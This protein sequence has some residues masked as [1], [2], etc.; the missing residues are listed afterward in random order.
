AE[1]RHCEILVCL[2]YTAKL[3]AKQEGLEDG[4]R[5]VINDGPKGCLSICVSHSCPPPWRAPNELASRLNKEVIVDIAISRLSTPSQFSIFVVGSVV[6]VFGSDS[7][8]VWTGL[9]VGYPGLG[10]RG[11]DLALGWC[12]W[13]LFQCLGLKLYD[14]VQYD[15]KEIAFP[16]LLPDPPHI[17]KS[18]KLTWHERFLI[19]GFPVPLYNCIFFDGLCDGEAILVLDCSLDITASLKSMALSFL[20]HSKIVSL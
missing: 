14:Y 16:S 18:R 9:S 15:L 2:L 13:A 4:F 20:Y 10:F 12:F 17:K 5:I 6:L 1:E 11:L 8:R 7:S 19:L 3:V